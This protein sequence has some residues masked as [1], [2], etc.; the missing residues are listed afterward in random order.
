VARDL[1]RGS[2]D[3]AILSKIALSRAI[4][5]FKWGVNAGRLVLVLVAGRSSLR[6]FE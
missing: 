4:W 5:D 1:D 6:P 3:S 2:M